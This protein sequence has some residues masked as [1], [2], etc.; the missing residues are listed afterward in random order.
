MKFINALLLT[1]LSGYLFP[2]FLPWWS[3]AITSFLI[4]V[5]IHQKPWKAFL[6][7]FIALLLLWGIYAIVIDNANQHILSTKVAQILPFNGSFTALII[8]TA[9]IGGLLSGMA[10]LTGSYLRGDGD[11]RRYRRSSRRYR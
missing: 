1:A 7:G 6:A 3:F 4:A 5:F 8:M 10:A 9:L 2:L 11:S